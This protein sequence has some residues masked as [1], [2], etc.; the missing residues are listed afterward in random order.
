VCERRALRCARRLLVSPGGLAD[1]RAV[2]AFAEE[3]RRDGAQPYF[4]L[5]P[6]A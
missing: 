6:A 3:A 5:Q 2:A 4:A 1:M